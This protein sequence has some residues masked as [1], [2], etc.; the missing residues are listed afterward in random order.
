MCI[1][2]HSLSHHDLEEGEDGDLRKCVEKS[3][4]GIGKSTRMQTIRGR[5]LAGQA[6]NNRWNREHFSRTDEIR[7]LA[8]HLSITVV[9]DDGPL[10]AI[11]IEVLSN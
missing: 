11:T 5:D 2:V 4:L 8:Y 6:H 10:V 1:P 7:V 3:G 9:I